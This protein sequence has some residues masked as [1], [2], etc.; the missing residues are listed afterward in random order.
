[1][2]KLPKIFQTEITKNIKN[3][4]TKCS[5]KN[6]ESPPNIEEFINKLFNEKKHTYKIKLE[7]KTK[8]KIYKTSI[9][10]KNRKSIITID[11]EIIPIKEIIEIKRT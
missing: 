5:L 8:K 7:I 11:N 6:K 10:S 1:M 3:N 9:I 2:K 4:Q